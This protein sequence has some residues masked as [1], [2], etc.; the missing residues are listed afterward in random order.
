MILTGLGYGMS[1]LFGHSAQPHV[2]TVDTTFH[3]IATPVPS[4]HTATPPS[5]PLQRL[6]EISVSV[7]AQLGEVFSAS[8]SSGASEG[9]LTITSDG[10]AVGQE[11]QVVDSEQLQNAAGG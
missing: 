3:D 11:F 4:E 5:S 7:I 9:G 10:T 8:A 2:L 6:S 1:L